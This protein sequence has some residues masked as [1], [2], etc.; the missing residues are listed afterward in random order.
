MAVTH[1][2]G[3]AVRP[4]DL[5]LQAEIDTDADTGEAWLIADT[6]A[7]YE[8]TTPA[9]LRSRIQQMRAQLENAERLA[10]QYEAI[11]GLRALVAEHQIVVEEWDPSTLDERLRD[12]FIGWYMEHGSTRVLVFPVGQDPIERLAAARQVMSAASEPEPQHERA[13]GSPDQL[14][15]LPRRT[16]GGSL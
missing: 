4:V 8:E 12:G 10:A 3:A 9:E 1:C 7:G 14:P 2:R 13:G 11:E 6:G 15:P 16:P 5:T